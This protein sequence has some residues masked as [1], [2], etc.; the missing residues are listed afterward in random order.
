MA[1]Y[2][3]SWITDSLALGHAPMSYADLDSLR[4]Q[5]VGAI[6]NLC[7]EFCDLHEI[8]EKHGFEVY[9]LPVLDNHVPL[10]PELEKALD[11]LDEAIYLGK[12]VLVHCRYGMGRTAT[13]VAAYLLRK[14]FGLKLARKKVEQ[15]RTMHSSFSQW[16]LLRKYS[17]RSGRLTIREP[18]LENRRV[19]DLDPFFHDYASLLDRVDETFREAAIAVPKLLLCGSETDLCCYNYLELSFIEACYLN[20]YLNRILPAQKRAEAIDRAVQVSRQT[21]TIENT[22]KAERDRLAGDALN[23]KDAYNRSKILCPLNVGGRCELY[24]YRPVACRMFGLGGEVNG[25]DNRDETA[26]ALTFH[27]IV[28]D[29]LVK[30]STDMFYALT[31]L[32]PEGEPP[33]F[34]LADAVSGR[35]IQDYFVFLSRL[36]DLNLTLETQT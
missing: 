5:G 28:Q 11:W 25:C 29:A 32:F 27:E 23:L 33:T 36:Q 30:I 16:R 18:S 3:A 15:A 35:F 13:F 12:K 14:G 2:K 22:L 26:T 34:T 6:M 4:E 19:V 7:A 8:E 24:A 9:Y 20:H 1:E 31:S 17:K 10:E 21:R